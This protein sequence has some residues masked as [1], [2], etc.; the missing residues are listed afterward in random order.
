MFLITDLTVNPP[1]TTRSNDMKDV[2][3]IIL[4]ITDAEDIAGD[5]LAIMS[6]MN[7]GCTYTFGPYFKIRCINNFTQKG[8]DIETIAAAATSLLATCTDDY[9]SRIWS[10]I[11]NDVI[12]DVLE[13][14]DE[15]ADGFTNGDVALAIGRAIASRFGVSA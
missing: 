4:G 10:C 15:C 1:R 14:T 2:H 12:I 13:C 5:A 11:E 3:D 8:P 9:A 7:I 6:Y